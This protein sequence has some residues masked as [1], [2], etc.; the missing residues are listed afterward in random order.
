MM[1]QLSVQYNTLCKAWLFW[2]MVS[3]TKTPFTG[4]ER[5]GVSLLVNIDAIKADKDVDCRVEQI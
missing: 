3:H 1:V 2:S 4:T 5:L